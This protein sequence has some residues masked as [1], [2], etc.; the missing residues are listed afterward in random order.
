MSA[1][2]ERK[3]DL[4]NPNEKVNLKKKV[5]IKKE[6]K[7][8]EHKVNYRIIFNRMILV[9]LVFSAIFFLIYNNSII[10]EKKLAIDNLDKSIM[11]AN[12][13]IESYNIVLE[14]L[15]NTSTI[16]S[17]ASNYLGMSYPNRKQTILV[18]VNYEDESVNKPEQNM[19][20]FDYI[21]GCFVKE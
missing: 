1:L 3:Y 14:N 5:P 12:D 10:T 15:N 7:K 4:D 19:N 21:L 17:Y 11:L 16:E 13:D 18:E 2:A 20:F 9:G 8:P 6:K